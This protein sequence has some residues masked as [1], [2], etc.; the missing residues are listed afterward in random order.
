MVTKMCI[1]AAN[2]LIQ[3]TNAY[4]SGKAYSERISMTCKRLQKLLYF[5]EVQFMVNNNGQSMLTDDFYA[6]PS[7]PVI[8]AVYK[9]FVQ[10]Q[11]GEMYPLDGEHSKLTTQMVKVL[12]FIFESTTDID[13]YDLVEMSHIKNGPWHR[14]YNE[15]DV[16]HEQIISKNSMF[17]FYKSRNIFGSNGI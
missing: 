12:D 3:K 11:S 7:G 10:F 9:K 6:W 16:N 17:D 13:T 14:V 15:S 8:P 2:Y 1:A 4:N 5:C